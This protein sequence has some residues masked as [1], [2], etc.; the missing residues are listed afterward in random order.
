MHKHSIFLLTLLTLLIT[1]GRTATA[2]KFVHPG[3]LHT[4]ADLNR[5]KAKVA[6]GEHP[7]IEGWER[8]VTDPKAQNTWRSAV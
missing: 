3:G 5:M 7:W 8:L 6:S 1:F 2:Q 4:E